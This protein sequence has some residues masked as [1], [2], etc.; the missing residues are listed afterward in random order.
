[1]DRRVSLS[2]KGAKM[3]GANVTNTMVSSRGHV[4]RKQEHV[5]D[6]FQK[7]SRVPGFS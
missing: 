2:S 4:S 1:M 7:S 3:D 5:S 6:V